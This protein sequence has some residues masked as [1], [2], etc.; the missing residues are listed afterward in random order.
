MITIYYKNGQNIISVPLTDGSVR[1]RVLMGENH[2]LLEFNLPDYINFEK[3]CYI[4]WGNERF[5]IMTNVYPERIKDRDGWSYS[6][7]FDAIDGLLRKYNVLFRYEDV[8]EVV[9]ALT[10]DLL[11]HGNLIADCINYEL[12][13]NNWS[14]KEIPEDLS[15]VSKLISYKGEKLFD[16]L[17]MIADTFECEWWTET[18][19][20]L[21]QI[22]FD[23][24]EYGTE[25]EL[26]IDEVVREIPKKNGD[27]SNYGTRFF[28][29]GSTRNLTKD[30]GQ[31]PQGGVTNH[32]SEIRLRLPDGMP[33][34]D[35]WDNLSEEDVVHQIAF[36][37]DIYPKNTETIT[38]IET[39][40]RPIEDSEDTFTA[41]IMVVDDTPFTPDHLIEGETLGCVFQTGILAG[42]EFDLQ[43]KE[44]N[45]DKRF[46]II[47]QFEGPE[48]GS[49]II[50]PN[51]FLKPE[52]GDTF[53]LTGVKLPDERIREAEQELLK[54]SQ[55]WAIRNSKD[56]NVYECPTNPVY[57]AENDKNYPLGQRVKIIDSRFGPSGRSSRIQGYEKSLAN[58]YEA[59]YIVGDNSPYSRLSAIE[60]NIK[61][62]Q[63][64]ERIG[65]SN[66][67]T[68][69]YLIR[70][71]YDTTQPTDYNAYSA[72]A[73]DRQITTRALS[74]LHPDIAHGI[75]Q[76]L[77]GATFGEFAGGF[78]GFGGKIDN[79]GNAELDSLSIRRFLEVPELRFNRIDI[80]I[81]DKW[82]SPGGGLIESVD[83]V[84]Q[85]VTLKLEE[86]EIGTVDVGDIC[87]GIFHS[88][89][90]DENSLDDYDD[91]KGNR[92]FAGFYTVYF[93]ITEVIGDDKSKFRYVLRPNYA[94]SFHPVESMNFVAYGN[95]DPDKKERQSSVYE[96]RTYTRYLKDVDD[97]EF[98]AR[99]IAAQFGDL[100]NLS[101]HNM[102]M[103][104]YSAYLNNIYM[105]GV[106]NQISQDGK[107]ERPL[108]FYKGKWE[109]K[110][111]GERYSYYDYV[112]HDGSLWLCINEDGTK[113]E[114]SVYSADW[115]PYLSS[116]TFYAMGRWKSDK[117][118]YKKNSIVTLGRAS[119]MAR[120]EAYFPPV[121]LIKSG[122][123]YIT[124]GGF[125]V[126]RGPENQFMNDDEWIMITPP[127]ADGSPGKDGKD[128]QDG[129]P[130]ED[131]LQGIQ[132]CIIRHAEWTIGT[133]WRNDEALTSGTRY[134]DVAMIRDSSMATGWRAYKCKQTHISG[135]NNAPPNSSFWDEFSANVTSLFTSLIIA[136]D[137]SIDF[138]QGNQL[139]IK[140]DDGAVTAGMSGST[141]GNKI[142]FW[143]GNQAPDN[144]PFRVDENG[145]LIAS[146]GEFTGKVNAT[147]GELLNVTITNSLTGSK[148]EITP[149][150]QM[151]L[152]DNSGSLVGSW[153]WSSGYSSIFQQLI[154][155]TGSYYSSLTPMALI[156]SDDTGSLDIGSSIISISAMPSIGSSF[157]KVFT[158]SD[159]SV[160]MR[161]LP[162]EQSTVNSPPGTV[163]QSNGFL[164][165]R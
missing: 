12:G 154:D 57:C 2:V 10:S 139:L 99:N 5:E 77:K 95:F 120:K 96:T 49:Q 153:K 103:D 158:G 62:S 34:I 87:M 81:G 61:E 37:D 118:P 79:N 82:R 111:E 52:V 121:G 115:T 53:I 100:S 86:G 92:R 125:Y 160:I 19:G 7:Q 89:N 129:K 50:I 18:N 14:V 80:N 163:Y 97:W 17:T 63:Y 156:I 130:G 119:F 114:P 65:V 75:I 98:S 15:G 88:Q 11:S 8:S 16:A 112:T 54:V 28:C 48:G 41:Y 148:L 85:I 46:E 3:G 22:C 51:E 140:K 44:T 76:F 132:G 20:N 122:D 39:V 109:D 43:I 144:A 94:T 56:T 13:G 145:K 72:L 47:A 29:F 25:E 42:R 27:E 162:D 6:I 105:T 135:A 151:N 136:K 141:D 142:R 73:T 60:G 137:A 45:F 78:S 4:D 149:N 134:L 90:E 40:Q 131:G 59:T 102:N 143:A 157:F 116:E 38:G 74:R 133:E 1:K 71:K 110:P 69:I 126:M 128:G 58:P 127:P 66:S 68:G 164:K 21:V 101:I 150:G 26:R 107:T 159:L 70:S 23:K 155:R 104:G 138:L 35:A 32:V 31:A 165:I 124:S 30:Y 83:T 64:A 9:F 55:A 84:N 147:S 152:Y 106:I 161:G 108:P 113:D 33:Y 93:R 36:F 117:V 146:N 67:G 24:M 91:S 123:N